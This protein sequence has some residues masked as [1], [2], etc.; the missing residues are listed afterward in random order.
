[1]SFLLDSW[2]DFYD[3]F[4]S[5]VQGDLQFYVETALDSGGPVLELGCGTGRVTIPIAESGVDIVGIDLSETMLSVAQ[6]KIDRLPD[7]SGTITLVHSD[8]RDFD[9]NECEKFNLA[10]IPFRGF[11]HLLNVDA[12]FKT[13]LNIRRHL[14]P[15][16]KLVFNVFVP[17][18]AILA[19]DGGPI[20]P[21]PDTTDPDTGERFLRWI[22]SSYD[23]YNQIWTAHVIAEEVDP[24][25]T[26][27]GRQH[28]D[29]QIR[30]A[31]RWELHHLLELCGFEILELYGSFD[32]GSFDE[33]STEMIW[34]VGLCS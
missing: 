9:F 3:A 17:D 2:A 14:A 12:Q 24:S 13:L 10:I 4:Y 21:L 30:Y 8:M 25:G 22:Q 16:G 32:R 33:N 26:S 27:I 1:M 34:V 5:N 29:F 28:R 23:N 15:D 18:P 31:H 11:L 7:D 19:E 6:K 20:V